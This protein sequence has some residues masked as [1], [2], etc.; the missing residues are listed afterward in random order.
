MSVLGLVLWSMTPLAGLGVLL[1]IGRFERYLLERG[2]REEAG[3]VPETLPPA[4]TP[5]M[6]AQQVARP[7]RPA[8]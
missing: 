6:N 3:D 8:A 4:I 2:E 5:S 7:S 1:G